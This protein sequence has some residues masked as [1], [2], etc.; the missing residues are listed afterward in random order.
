MPA[1]LLKERETLVGSRSH[2]QSSGRGDAA[3]EGRRGHFP[4]GRAR[5]TTWRLERVMC[6]SH[7]LVAFAT[8]NLGLEGSMWDRRRDSG[9]KSW[10]CQPGKPAAG[11]LKGCLPHME[12]HHWRLNLKGRRDSACKYL[13]WETLF[14][15]VGAQV[16]P[17]VGN[18]E[19]LP[20][21]TSLA[22]WCQVPWERDLELCIL[23]GP[24]LLQ[25][26]VHG[27]GEYSGTGGWRE[28]L[29]QC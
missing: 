4:G 7:A 19:Y 26:G 14:W 25:G 1:T 22:M 20:C 10:F 13:W 29:N 2:R 6:R 15:L 28:A 11:D 17:L 5:E 27:G 23:G 18:F 24:V 16:I 9:L 21:I 3:S 12:E 8:E